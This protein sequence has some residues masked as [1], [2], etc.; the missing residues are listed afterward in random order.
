LG[1]RSLTDFSVESRKKQ[2]QTKCPICTLP[3][4]E[5]IEEA[6]RNGV[7]VTEIRAW[8]INELGLDPEQVTKHKVT[9]HWVEGHAE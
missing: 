7:Y 9:K 1:H 8:L 5:E 3:E 4:R 2:R 6:K